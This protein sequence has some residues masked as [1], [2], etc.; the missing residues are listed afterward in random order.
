M[1]VKRT[2]RKA[3]FPVAGLGT[4]FHTRP[5]SA[6]VR[7]IRAGQRQLA[8]RRPRHLLD[9]DW[10]RNMHNA[11]DVVEKRWNTWVINYNFQ[12]Q[13]SLFSGLGLDGMR[14][15]GL[16]GI[17]FAVLAVMG[18]VLL[19]LLLRTRGPSQ[20]DPVQQAWQRFLKQ[21]R[22][23]G[24]ESKPSQGAME[25]AADAAVKLPEQA[26]AIQKVTE[27]YNRYRYASE[28]PSLKELKSAIREFGRG[29]AA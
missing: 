20:H 18:L 3:V 29:R 22:K 15:A 8:G 6:I 4:R 25:L 1:S 17:L 23:A 21:L 2:V 13:S 19:P 9:F 24:Y 26:A 11:F 27:L 16:V 5:V 12:R 14:P 7:D 10:F 28:R